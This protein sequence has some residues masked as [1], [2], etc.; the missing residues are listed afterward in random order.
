MKSRLA[1]R[2]PL[3]ELRKPEVVHLTDQAPSTPF[4]G[5]QAPS[6]Q[7]DNGVRETLCKI[8]LDQLLDSPYQPRLKYNPEEIDELAA[9]MKAN[10]QQEPVMVRRLGTASYQLIS[11]HRRRR[12]AQSIGWTEL[13][14]R[15]VEADNDAAELRTMIQNEGRKDLCDYEKGRM[16]QHAFARNFVK[17]QAECASVF[18]T[19]Q[20]NVSKRMNLLNLPSPITALLD[21]QPDLLSVRKAEVIWELLKAYPDEQDLVVRAVQRLADG[22]DISTLR[23]WVAQMSV[24]KVPENTGKGPAYITNDEGTT[25]YETKIKKSTRQILLT[26]KDTDEDLESLDKSLITFL[27]Q[28]KEEKR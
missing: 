3:A 10:G 24:K 2:A 27:R 14:A 25:L 26:V 18:A 11:G 22:A 19:S 4:P 21:Q 28:R 7:V 23:G 16:Y 12:A 15:I 9:G 6:E 8:P 17:N 1:P 5:P 13:E 20:A